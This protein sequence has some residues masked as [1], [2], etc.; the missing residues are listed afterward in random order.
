MSKTIF[1][2]KPAIEIASSAGWCFGVE[3]IV[4]LAE[5]LLASEPLPVYCLGELIHNPQEVKRFEEKGMKFVTSVEKLPL[6]KPGESRKILIRAHGI[7]PQVR[8]ALQERQWEIVDGTC[9]LVTIPHQFAKKI[10]EDGYRLVIMGHEEHPEIQGILGEVQGL[11]VR[12]DVI[13]GPEAIDQ[14]KLRASDRVGL[15]SQTTHPYEKFAQ[16]IGEVL[17]RCL[18][19]RAYNTICQA[20]FDRQ[21]A[22]R[23]LAQR[24]D[25][26]IVV[27]GF[28]SSN[29]ARLA[30][31]AAEYTESYHIEDVGELKGEWLNEKKHIGI[32]AGASTPHRCIEEVKERIAQLTVGTGAQVSTHVSG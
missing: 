14:L 31:I 15:I 21:D 6:L 28:K 24:S 12:V 16:L 5:K 17:K 27:G 8:R 23:E 10:A 26:V 1:S 9:P 18:E 2:E 11:K 22:I 19:V 20:T 25:I 4:D 7:S 3:R 29:T 32:S 13:A 30:E